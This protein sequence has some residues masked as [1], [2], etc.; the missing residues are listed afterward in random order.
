MTCSTLA[1]H[2]ERFVKIKHNQQTRSW[3]AKY[4]QPMVDSLGAE[5][6]LNTVGRV[7]AETYWQAI[8]ART[9]CWES[10]PYKPTQTRPLAITT[11]ANHLRAARCFWNEMVRQSL[12]DYNPFD[13]LKAP[14]DTQPVEMKAIAPENL[15]AIWKAALSSS[16]RDFAL[17]TVMATSGVRAGELVSMDLKHINLKA[18]EVWVYG[19]RGWRKVFL[20]KA[21]V[22]TIQAYLEERTE[23]S[24]PALW[25][26]RYGEPLTADG[27]RRLVYRLAEQAQVEGRHNLHAFRHRAAQAWL[28]DGLNAEIVMQALGHANVTV[29]LAIYSNQDTQRVRK[30]MRQAELAPFRD[31]YGVEAM[32]L[33]DLMKFLVN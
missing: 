26:G 1:I 14:R 10:H 31:P 11:Q 20:G 4:L 2:V 17:I 32:N 16:K 28:D 25:L 19:K 13:H 7:E 5:R 27:V 6:L 3:Y 29:T 24:C 21:S 23:D 22:E 30:A 8:C 9:L 18:G 15:R 12:V 33:P